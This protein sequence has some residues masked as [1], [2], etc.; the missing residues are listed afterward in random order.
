MEMSIGSIMNNPNNRPLETRPAFQDSNGSEPQPLEV[1]SPIQATHRMSV[2]SNNEDGESGNDKPA[3]RQK[4]AR[5]CEACRSMKI[6]C[7]PVEG[8]EACAACA[9]VNRHCVMPGPARK[10]QKT[11]HK[12]AEL[13]KKIN[14]LSSLLAQK[15]Q[16]TPSSTDSPDTGKP[17]K[18][19]SEPHVDTEHYCEDIITKQFPSNPSSWDEMRRGM[20]KNW[21]STRDDTHVDVI[22]KGLISVEIASQV[23]QRYCNELSRYTPAV[24][25][26]PGTKEDDIR[27]NK[28]ILYLAIMAVSSGTICPDLQPDIVVELTRQ[29]SDRV[30]YY[31][32]KSLEMIQAL[33]MYAEWYTRSKL[34]KDLGFNQYIHAAVVMSLDIGL[35]R[36]SKIELTQDPAEAVE[37]R[38]TWLGCFYMA[39]RF[40]VDCP[41]SPNFANC[42]SVPPR[43]SG[44]PPSCGFLLM[45]KS[46]LKS[47]KQVHMHSP[48]IAGWRTWFASNASPRTS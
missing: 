26:S 14:A 3:K 34:A 6:R 40:V 31:C 27:K 25:F 47:S 16:D 11:V 41:W 18:G 32:E 48:V 42:H 29:L 38:R 45:S 36:R 13:E 8:Q 12:V 44:I 1:E 39:V 35:G 5:A 30:M 15:Q 4:R 46:A 28:P 2:D 23:F 7:N 17:A 10:R 9:K 19:T 22:D 24:A 21:S 33:L 37:I 43:F 20:S